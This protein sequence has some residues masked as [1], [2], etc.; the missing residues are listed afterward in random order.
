MQFFSFD[1]FVFFLVGGATF[2]LAASESVVI[3]E[4][5][6]SVPEPSCLTC[7][8]SRELRLVADGGETTEAGG[9]SG[10]GGMEGVSATA[11]VLALFSFHWRPA[12]SFSC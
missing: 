8:E 7:P 12:A 2:Y 10:R 9:A 1:F 6:A 5:S 4:V 11:A 3:V